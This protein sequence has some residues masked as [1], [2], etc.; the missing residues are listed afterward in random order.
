ML[1]NEDI[2]MI[3]G[4]A[5]NSPTVDSAH[6]MQLIVEL[7]IAQLLAQKNYEAMRLEERRVAERQAQIVEL[8]A[9]RDA[10]RK[11]IAR[12]WRLLVANTSYTFAR[13]QFYDSEFQEVVLAALDEHATPPGA[14]KE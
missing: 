13:G 12:L 11:I 14:G 2:A 10:S 1:T 6:V 3:D 4:F 8:T 7:R 5:K 9:E